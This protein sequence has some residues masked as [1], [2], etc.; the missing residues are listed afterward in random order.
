MQIM[1]DTATWMND[2]FGTTYKIDTPADNVMLG[3]QYLAWL[4]SYWGTELEA[5]NADGTFNL[6]DPNLLNGVIS[7]YNWGTGGVDPAK[8]KAGIPNG[9]YVDNVKALMVSCC[10]NY[11]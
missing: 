7:S 3:G 9:R 8:G 1:P 6:N 5:F 11:Y 10:A 2:R 4:I